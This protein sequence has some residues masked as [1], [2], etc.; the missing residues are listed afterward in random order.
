MKSLK[1]PSSH[2]VTKEFAWT[3]RVYHED[4][5]ILGLVYY[6]NYL[7]F[8]ERARTEWL[9]A[10][11][12]EQTSL[13]QHHTLAFV[14]KQL[15]IDYRKPALF[16]DTLQITVG[17]THL[18]RASLTVEQRVLRHSEVLCT[19]I[20]KLACIDTINLRPRPLTQD[21]VKALLPL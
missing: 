8:M 20:V 2:L 10:K 9:H 7:K 21:L 13:K 3:V 14:V 15:E 11:G 5:D 17:L 1:H 4:T 6:A 18:G 19:A 16:E 12:F